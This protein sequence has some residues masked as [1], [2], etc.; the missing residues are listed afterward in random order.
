MNICLLSSETISPYI[1]KKLNSCGHKSIK[2]FYEFKQ[3]IY[4]ENIYEITI[5]VDIIINNE[6]IEFICTKS[7]IFDF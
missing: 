4:K 5:L 3:D 7:K 6:D 2:V 1:I